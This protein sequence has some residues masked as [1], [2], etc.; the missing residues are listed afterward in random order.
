MGGYGHDTDHWGL[1]DTNL[2]LQ[3]SKKNPRPKQIAEARDSYNNIAAQTFYGTVTVFDVEC[4]YK[5]KGGTKNLNTLKIGGDTS[6][7]KV[8]TAI[9][10]GTSQT[11][12]PEFTVKGVHGAVGSVTGPKFTLPSITVTG[13][14]RAQG[15]GF[16]L[17]EGKLTGSSLSAACELAEVLDSA[18]EVA[19]HGV[20]GATVEVSGDATEIDTEVAVTFDSGYTEVQGAGADKTNTAYGTTSFSGAKFLAKDP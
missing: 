3:G 8:K 15:L 17:T 7:T 14:K 11:D 1:A 19:A 5:L 10:V 2:K 4:T 12:W 6:G 20:S 13:A 16:A 18:G 9:D